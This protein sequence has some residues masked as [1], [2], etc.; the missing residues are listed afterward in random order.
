M[1]HVVQAG[2]GPSR[3]REREV[4]RERERERY[5]ERDRERAER[6]TEREKER[7]GGRESDRGLKRLGKTLND[8]KRLNKIELV[9]Q[10]LEKN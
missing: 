10:A 8:S 7:M 4:G 9:F 3:E 1:Q 6:E 5:I 2:R